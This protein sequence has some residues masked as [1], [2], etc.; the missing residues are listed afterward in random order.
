MKSNSLLDC[1]Q[2]A[3]LCEF[4]PSKAA[5]ALKLPNY[6]SRANYKTRSKSE[7][8]SQSVLDYVSSS[9]QIPS[10]STIQNKPNYADRVLPS[11]PHE[12][13]YENR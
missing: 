5:E 9:Q 13:L 6:N 12:D 11:E 2:L 7:S 1:K 8:V 3:A 10:S 4:D